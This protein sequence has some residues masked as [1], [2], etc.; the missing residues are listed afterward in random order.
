MR[1]EER[2]NL[3][4]LIEGNP[5]VFPLVESATTKALFDWGVRFKTPVINTLPVAVGPFPAGT[6]NHQ[7][8]SRHPVTGQVLCTDYVENKGHTYGADLP[9]WQKRAL[10]YWLQF[11]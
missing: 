3:R 1:D 7:V 4:A 5:K 2:T 10:I 8:F 9:H 6:P 11:Q